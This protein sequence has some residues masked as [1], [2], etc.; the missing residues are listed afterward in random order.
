MVLSQIEAE[1]LA[2]IDH[3]MRDT[4]ASD[5]SGHDSSHIDRVLALAKKIL[6]NEPQADE[7]IVLAAATLHDTYDDKLF[8][9]PAAA[10]NK[11]AEFLQSISVDSQSMFEIIDNMSW[12]AQVFGHHKTLDI[13]GQIVQDADRLEAIGA[14]AI[15]RTF[16]YGFAHDQID[17]DPAIKPRDLKSKSE[18]R[19]ERQPILNHFYEKLFKIK[20]S[21]NTETA[22]KLAVKRDKFMH[23]FVAE[24]L[25]EYQ[26]KA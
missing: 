7:F 12:S 22:K 9:D 25:A 26:L 17:Y 23:D 6:I 13:N 5:Q 19:N 3:F 21:L 4:L 20:D 8:K 14:I 1:K 11:L 2:K 16:K 24:Y 18:Y 10:K 15:I